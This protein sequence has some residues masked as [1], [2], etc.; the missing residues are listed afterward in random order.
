MFLACA[1]AVI[2]SHRNAA[3]PTLPAL[4][5]RR[6]ETPHFIQLPLV[7]SRPFQYFYATILVAYLSHSSSSFCGQLSRRAIVRARVAPAARPYFSW[8]DFPVLFWQSSAR[9]QTRWPVL[10]GTLRSAAAHSGQACWHVGP[11]RVA[12]RK[13]PFAGKLRWPMAPAPTR[14]LPTRWHPIHRALMVPRNQARRVIRHLQR[15]CQPIP[16][17]LTLPR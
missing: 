6:L 4:L 7:A 8:I 16:R 17:S 13:T 14:Q 3:C 1:A 15:P 9:N 12:H 5:R 2:A 10:V 11:R